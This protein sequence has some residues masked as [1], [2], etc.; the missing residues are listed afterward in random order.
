MLGLLVTGIKQ[1][2]GDQIN[3]YIS[4]EFYIPAPSLQFEGTA[5][6]ME[7]YQSKRSPPASIRSAS[8]TH[9]MPMR[10]VKSSPRP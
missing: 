1:H 4:N 2:L 8:P 5:K 10:P 9:P 6:M 3:G 7:T